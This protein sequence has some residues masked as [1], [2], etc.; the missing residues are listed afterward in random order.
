MPDEL[1]GK[2]S[3]I[4]NTTPVAQDDKAITN[5]SQDVI[6]SVVENDTDK[7]GDKLKII[8]AE[9]IHGSV[10]IENN[11]LRYVPNDGFAGKDKITY[12]IFDGQGSIPSDLAEKGISINIAQLC[13]GMT[14]C[15]QISRGEKISLRLQINFASNDALVTKDYYS[16]IEKLVDAM[17][18][19]PEA[20][21]TIEGHSSA[22]GSTIYNKKLS[23]QRAASI[24]K[25]LIE[26][27]N[28]SP[29]R[30]KSVGYGE[31]QL[32]NKEDTEQAHSQ[33]RRIVAVFDAR[34]DNKS[35][36]DSGVA[37]AV[38]IVNIVKKTPWYVWGD[39]GVAYTSTSIGEL[40]NEIT[41][42][43]INAT[44]TSFES[45]RYTSQF[46]LGY[47][48]NDN[49][50]F[51]MGYADLGEVA[52]TLTTTESNFSQLYNDISKIHPLSAKGY[53]LA[54]QY[55]KNI[56]A[57]IGMLFR[58]GYCIWDADYKT[59]NIS[60]VGN[61]SLGGNLVYGLGLSY[62]LKNNIDVRLLLQKFNIGNSYANF[63]STGLVYKFK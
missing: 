19:V 28:I 59:Y 13:P 43:G 37:S 62:Q 48:L 50:A 31:E 21:V 25:I 63:I 47:R 33:N 23:E 39:A 44:V 2:V 20:T 1:V 8:H 14:V 27:F 36:K 57:D 15:G 4:F 32:I 54:T 29:V 46:G 51:E 18:K 10:S 55:H 42:A 17:A 11:K 24:A 35:K 40:N 61:D 34:F 56:T 9:A 26:H 38:V 12:F 41:N 45:S 6:I 30:V 7:D 3:S 5:K 52:I 60:T 49:W 53:L 22:V 58:L 16:E